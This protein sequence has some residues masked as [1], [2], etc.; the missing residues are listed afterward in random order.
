MRH[1]PTSPSPTCSDAR[2]PAKLVLGL[3]AGDLCVVRV[4]GNVPGTWSIG[5]IEFA[6]DSLVPAV[7]NAAAS[8]TEVDGTEVATRSGYRA[9]LVELAVLVTSALTTS[10]LRQTFA[11]RLGETLDVVYGVYD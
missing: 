4:A 1:P 2:V 5:S 9:A 10:V 8:M 11:G 6:V 3:A 7:V